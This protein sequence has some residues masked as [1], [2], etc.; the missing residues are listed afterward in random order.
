MWLWEIFIRNLV[1]INIHHELSCRHANGV[2]IILLVMDQEFP[3]LYLTLKDT[4][5]VHSE[6]HTLVKSFVFP[7]SSWHHSVIEVLRV[8]EIVL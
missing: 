5:E 6:P 7:E 3:P 8:H 1:L 4:V 2:V